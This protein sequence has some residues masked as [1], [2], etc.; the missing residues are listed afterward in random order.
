MI[1]MSGL[2]ISINPSLTSVQDYL[3][4]LDDLDDLP[5]EIFRG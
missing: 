1:I 3:A 4:D 2:M 5:K